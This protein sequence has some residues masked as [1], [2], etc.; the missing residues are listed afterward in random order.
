M[1]ELTFE[2]RLHIAPSKEEAARLRDVLPSIPPTD[3]ERWPV[4]VV[5]SDWRAEQIISVPLYDNARPTG[6][7][8]V[9]HGFRV[10][11]R[12]LYIANPKATMLRFSDNPAV[13]F[14]FVVPR[15]IASERLVKLLLAHVCTSQTYRYTKLLDHQRRVGRSLEVLDHAGCV[16]FR[17]QEDAL[18][19]PFMLPPTAHGY[20]GGDGFMNLKKLFADPQFSAYLRAFDCTG[21]TVPLDGC[22]M[23]QILANEGANDAFLIEQHCVEIRTAR[24]D[25]Y[26]GDTPIRCC[27]YWTSAW[28][29]FAYTVGAKWNPRRTDMIDVVQES[30]DVLDRE[31][32]E[33]LE[34]PDLHATMAWTRARESESQ[35]AS[36]PDSVLVGR[37][38]SFLRKPARQ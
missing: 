7:E 2:V 26:G 1:S 28:P 8:V 34:K 22:V 38:L 21:D 20:G 19:F 27:L 30:R 24:L 35:W 37:I 9:V 12:A 36:L 5:K 3:D 15:K 29:M 10:N 16:L 32:V 17:E 6:A 18:W 23:R 33:F 25:N 11:K 4:V 13:L 14:A 31:L